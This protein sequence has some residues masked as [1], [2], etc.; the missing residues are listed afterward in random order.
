MRVVKAEMEIWLTFF[1]V[2]TSDCF[3]H[4][5]H[6]EHR[7]QMQ[8]NTCLSQNSKNKQKKK[9]SDLLIRILQ[10]THYNE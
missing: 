1:P 8:I 6:S 2:L 7:F 5:M 3:S 10:N 4:I 9:K